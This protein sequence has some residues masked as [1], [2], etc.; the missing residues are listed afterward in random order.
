M[1]ILTVRVGMACMLKLMLN[2]DSCSSS[3]SDKLLCIKCKVF[4]LCIL[5][6][7][8]LPGSDDQ[9]VPGQ[10]SVLWIMWYVGHNVI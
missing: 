7:M 5:L 10:H 6:S 2:I 9:T 3:S 4:L 1:K 8:K